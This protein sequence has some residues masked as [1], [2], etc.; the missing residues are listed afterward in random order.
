MIL[1]ASSAGSVLELS[2]LLNFDR[3]QSATYCWH[4]NS[5]L[6]A[7]FIIITEFDLL[8]LLKFSA[9]YSNLKHKSQLNNQAICLICLIG[10]I[11]Q[12][13]ICLIL[14]NFKVS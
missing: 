6:D 13:L 12:D 7:T 8:V 5:S 10:Q 11:S 3:R 1:N 9:E 2:R 14:L 4:D